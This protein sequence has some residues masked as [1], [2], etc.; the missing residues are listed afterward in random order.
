M[1]FEAR[2][3]ANL[4]YQQTDKYK[5]YKKDYYMNNVKQQYIK[6][7]NKYFNINDEYE[8]EFLK[9]INKCDSTKQIKTLCYELGI[10][11]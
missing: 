1:S 2:K 3:R 7:A 8:T 5:K 4:K 11:I 6:R 9:R 10:D